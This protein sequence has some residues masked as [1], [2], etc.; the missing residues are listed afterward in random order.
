VKKKSQAF[1][2]MSSPCQVCIHQ[3]QGS[4]VTE[5]SQDKWHNNTA[6]QGPSFHCCRTNKVAAVTKKPTISCK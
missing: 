5:H 6:V 1:Y 3:Q 4:T 2:F